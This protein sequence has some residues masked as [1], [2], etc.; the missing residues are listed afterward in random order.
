MLCIR[1]LGSITLFNMIQLVCPAYP[2]MPTASDLFK[3]RDIAF[4]ALL[5]APQMPTVD[6]PLL[7]G[8]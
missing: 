4:L 1:A 7:L 8:V 2:T 5:S 3:D 6:L